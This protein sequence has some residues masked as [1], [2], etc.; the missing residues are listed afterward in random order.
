MAAKAQAE[1]LKKY[2]SG[3]SGGDDKKTKKKKKVKAK[4]VQSFK[5]VDADEEARAT[6]KVIDVD[7]EGIYF[8]S[9]NYTFR[10]TLLHHE[11][12]RTTTQ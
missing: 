8:S 11:S 6:N 1:Y 4:P 9:Y 12:S 10:P 7:E 3:S 5:I 2:K